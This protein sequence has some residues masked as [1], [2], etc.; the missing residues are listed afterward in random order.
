MEEKIVM[1]MKWKSKLKKFLTE[2]LVACLL[3][4]P[5]LLPPAGSGE[6]GMPGE[7]LTGSEQPGGDDEGADGAMP[8]G[9][10]GDDKDF[11]KNNE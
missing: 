9:D 2:A 5:T 6:A 4:A 11:E 3:L 10:L 7:V 1:G 8:C